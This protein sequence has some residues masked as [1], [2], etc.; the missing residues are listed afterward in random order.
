MKHGNHQDE[1]QEILAALNERELT[2]WER[3][4]L[5]EILENDPELI[6]EFTEH[7]FLEADLSSLQTY[8]LLQAGIEPPIHNLVSMPS[9][10]KQSRSST[11]LE[12]VAIVAGLAACV[13]FALIVLKNPYSAPD[14]LVEKEA[15]TPEREPT[16]S[17]PVRRANLSLDDPTDEAVALSGPVALANSRNPRG[18]KPEGAAS[19]PEVISFNHHVRPI[20]SENCFFCH[21]PDEKTQEANLRLDNAEGATADLGGYAA[22]VPGDPEKSE[23]WIRILSDDPDE[24]MPPLDSHRELSAADR[25]ILR[26]WIEEGAEYQKHWA[27]ISPTRPEVPKVESAKSPIDAF[28]LSR[29]EH[30]GLQP[31]PMADAR[32]ILRRLSLDLI[33]LPPTPDQLA[34]FEEA[35][36]NDTNSA[37][38]NAIDE[39]LTSP[40]FGERMALPWLDAARYADSNGFQQDGNRHQW[41]WRDWVI[42]AYNENKPFDQFTIEQLAGDLL[43]NATQDQI[44]ATAFNRNHMLNG[45]GGAIKEEQRINYVIDRVDT[46]ATTWLAL[47]MACAQCH[48]HKYDP[49]SHEEYFQFFAF[50]NN[51]PESGGVDKRS[52]QGCAFGSGSTVQVAR[53]WLSLPSDEQTAEIQQLNGKIKEKEKATDTILPQLDPLRKQWESGFST[54]ELVDRTRFPGSISNILR[55]PEDQRRPNQQRDITEFYLLSGNHDNKDWKGLGE[56]IKDLRA[57]KRKIEESIVEIMVMEENPPE[58]QRETFV[59]NRGDYQQPTEKVTA[60]TPAF[61]P[62][63]PDNAP[64]NRLGLAQWLVD[65]QHPLTARVMVNRIWQQFFGTGIVK[66]SEDFGVQ[67]ELPVHPEL[68]DWLAVEFVES[69]WDVKHIVHLI[70]SSSTYLQDSKITPEKYEHDPDNRLLARGV[71]SRLPAMLLRDQALAV[72]GLLKDQIGGE[73]VYPHQPEGLWQ[74]FSFGKISYPHLEEK[75]QLHRRSIYTFWRRT[76]SPPNMFDSSSRQVCTVKPSTTNTPLHALTLMNDETYVEAARA[77]AERIVQEGGDRPKSRLTLAFELATGQ[78]PDEREQQLLV[79]GYE[80]SLNEFE[81][82]S[83]NASH[84]VAQSETHQKPPTELAAYTRMAQVILNLDQTLNNP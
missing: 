31:N 19:V 53:P 30:E 69:G 20:L 3:E 76:S 22:I 10:G 13:G 42:R 62:S 64:Q 7:C 47:T 60:G 6:T 61:L 67:G 21:G 56:E 14:T 38:E 36:A 4:R 58:K 39:L 34:T 71:R 43:P 74:E 80:R 5:W 57:A 51:I 72:S 59:L 32:T 75:T 45:E 11:W 81:S 70:V 27:F 79:N 78:L 48:S 49:I 37:I 46:T 23:V 41:P 18:G 15:R 77:L 82:F 29:L 84:Y 50:F 68:L 83:E 9:S 26:R 66:T 28:I 17:P 63:L 8:E 16:D 54:A 2:D 33:G 44:I 52:G 1:F 73:P 12:N 65:P 55:T 40:H 35:F 24:V 25:E